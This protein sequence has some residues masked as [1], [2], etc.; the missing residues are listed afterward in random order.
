[1]RQLSAQLPPDVS[2]TELIMEKHRAVSVRGMAKTNE[3]VAES[4]RVVRA[5]PDF[6]DVRLDY[7]SGVEI[8]GQPVVE[9]QLLCRLPAPQTKT[10]LARR[11]QR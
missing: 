5:F 1:M 4:L 11:A 2:V 10:T 3:L 6:V 8:E 7:A 9:F